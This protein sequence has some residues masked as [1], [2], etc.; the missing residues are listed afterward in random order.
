M[1]FNNYI[2]W[3]KILV[4][5]NVISKSGIWRINLFLKSNKERIKL[6]YIDKVEIDEIIEYLR[7]S[8]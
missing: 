5:E 1:L 8:K 7:T 2:S 3:E 6:K 4:N